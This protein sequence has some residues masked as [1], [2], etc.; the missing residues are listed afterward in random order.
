MELRWLPTACPEL[1]P[2]ENLWREIKG[3]ILANEATPDLGASL[4]RAF[5][6]LMS[7]RPRQRLKTAGVL[8]RNFW[9]P[10]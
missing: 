1:N 9:L 4:L 6:H 2:L 5:E 7:M 8:S 3:H 10:T